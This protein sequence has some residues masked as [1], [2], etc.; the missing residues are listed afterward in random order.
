MPFT[1]TH[2]GSRALRL[3]TMARWRRCSLRRHHAGPPAPPRDSHLAPARLGG[4]GVPGG[5]ALRVVAR[6][7]DAHRLRGTVRIA[8]DRTTGGRRSTRP[9]QWSPN[10]FVK[11]L[12]ERLANDPSRVVLTRVVL[13]PVDV[14]VVRT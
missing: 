3:P 8:R 7:V 5:R 4:V 1:V 14:L 13:A 12:D 6:R 9:T 10:R 2:R 11:R